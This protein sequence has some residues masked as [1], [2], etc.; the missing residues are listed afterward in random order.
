MGVAQAGHSEG[1]TVGHEDPS[2]GGRLGRVVDGACAN[3][4]SGARHVVEPLDAIAVDKEEPLGQA[5][6]GERHGTI[7]PH[8]L[9]SA[10]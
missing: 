6:N 8:A 1:A 3:G 7:I 5:G 4:E 2:G 10:A 9:A